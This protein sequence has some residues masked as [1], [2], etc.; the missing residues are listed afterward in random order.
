[1]WFCLQ[2]L[3]HLQKGQRASEANRTKPKKLMTKNVFGPDQ[4]SEL[5]DFPGVNTPLIS[6]WAIPL[7]TIIYLC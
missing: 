6:G 5:V 7:T 4:T 3:V 2:F 1:M